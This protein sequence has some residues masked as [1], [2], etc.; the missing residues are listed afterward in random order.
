MYKIIDIYW[1]R[2][3]LHIIFDNIITEDVYLLRQTEE[4]KLDVVN[5]NKY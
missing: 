4:I 5:D 2:S 3:N 1:E